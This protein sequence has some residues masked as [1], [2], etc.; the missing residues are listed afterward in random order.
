MN[1]TEKRMLEN[2]IERIA[3]LE[4]AMLVLTKR[5]QRSDDDKETLKQWRELTTNN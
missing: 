1:Y 4:A 2:A 3:K 5:G